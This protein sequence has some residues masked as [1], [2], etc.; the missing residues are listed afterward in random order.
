MKNIK[1]VAREEESLQLERVSKVERIDLIGV[2][3]FLCVLPPC[4]VDL[5]N[6]LK[7]SIIWISY[8]EEFKFQK[9]A[10]L[11]IYSKYLIH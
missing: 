7:T 11:L 6:S 9:Q 8:L 5:V 1:M 3:N 10:K 2:D 4:F